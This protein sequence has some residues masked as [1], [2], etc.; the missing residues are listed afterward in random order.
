MVNAEVQA[1][2]TQELSPEERK[3]TCNISDHVVKVDS[4]LLDR[5][6]DSKKRLHMII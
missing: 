4:G 2:E 5:V 6:A 3:N 1:S